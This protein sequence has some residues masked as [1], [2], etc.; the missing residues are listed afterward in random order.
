MRTPLLCAWRKWHLQLLQRQLTISSAQ[1]YTST[2]P[3]SESQYII[4]RVK[5][6]DH[7][8]YILMMLAPKRS[9][10][11]LFL[12]HIYLMVLSFNERQVP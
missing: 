3:Q 11:V 4:D 1:R 6:Y 5:S 2:R 10:L 8:N 7:E 12:L 9:R